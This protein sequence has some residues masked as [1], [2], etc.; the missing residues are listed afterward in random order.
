MYPM[1]RMRR[2]RRAESRRRLIRETTLSP[3]HLVFPILV[4][5]GMN[6][7]DA[8]KES[9]VATYS[10]DRLHD[11]VKQLKKIGITSLYLYGQPE[12]KDETASE[13]YSG[14]GTI[15]R[16]IRAVKHA[17]PDMVVMTD[18][19]LSRYT[20]H[21]YPGVLEADV[22]HNEATVEVLQRVA[23]SHAG[24]GA[25]MIT[26][27]DMTD[28]GVMAIRH[29]LEEHGYD[30]TGIIAGSAIY[31]STFG[32]GVTT[33]AP[34]EKGV[35]PGKFAGDDSE[36]GG[37]LGGLFGFTGGEDGANRRDLRSEVYMDPANSSEAL[38]E[39]ALN[40][41]EG[42][43]IVMVSPGLTSLDIIRRMKDTFQIPVASMAG[44]KETLMLK[45]AV[46]KGI[47]DEW[48][49]VIEM[50]VVQVRA[51]ADLLITPFAREAAV[52][53]NDR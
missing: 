23:L 35:G 31:H 21:G 39:T 46:R 27:T 30:E 22:L 44:E 17:N 10:V 49:S 36:V 18:I 12:N 50:L 5:P 48:Q 47:I 24:C 29:A 25:D 40:F 11:L 7:D 4:V 1:H 26:T 8:D 34:G 32:F 6:K 33:N 13:A 28:G 51:G 15:Q 42:A 3:E 53:L 2:L 14:A 41:E 37:P 19:C 9:W 45:Y 52:H 16:A 20:D 43:D 38:R